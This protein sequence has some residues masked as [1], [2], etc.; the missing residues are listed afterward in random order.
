[1]V[2]G[3]LLVS[4]AAAAI[5]GRLGDIYGRKRMILVVLGF[6]I[7]GS[8]ISAATQS[9]PVMVIGRAMQGM[10]GAL[11]PLSFG[12]ISVRQDLRSAMRHALSNVAGGRD[13]RHPG[14][15]D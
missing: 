4:A 13:T 2:T 5:C 14:Q 9:L 11:M 3:Y 1:M 10:S 12:L 7:L 8:L 6:A 15:Q